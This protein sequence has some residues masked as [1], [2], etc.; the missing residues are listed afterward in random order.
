MGSAPRLEDLHSSLTAYSLSPDE[1]ATQTPPEPSAPAARLELLQHFDTVFKDITAE[2]PAQIEQAF[3]LRYQVYCVEQGFEAP[4]AAAG[5]IE[6][7]RYDA[8]AH[9]SLLV[10]QTSALPLGTV[11]LVKPAAKADWIDDLPV[12]AYAAP[13]SVD[14]LRSLPAGSTAEVSR[15][16]IAR[17]ARRQL[18]EPQECAAPESG[19]PHQDQR[20]RDKLRPYMSLGLIR[21]LVRLSAEQGITHWC[22]AAEPTLLRRLRAFGLHFRPAGPLV[23]HRGLRQVCYAELKG[24]LERARQEHPEFWHIMTQG[25]FLAPAQTIAAAA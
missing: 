25:G 9:H 10:D 19:T 18:A 4:D 6:R 20:W 7:D 14:E 15:F 21:G 13:E 17:I 2:R 16:A 23:D 12:A 5:E 3:R 1:N 24:L 8:Y 22:L 11:R